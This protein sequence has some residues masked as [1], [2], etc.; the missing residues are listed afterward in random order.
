MDVVL[1]EE[2]L[3]PQ[4]W[5]GQFPR[6]TYLVFEK[7][8]WSIQKSRRNIG[9][10]HAMALRVAVSFLFSTVLVMFQ[11]RLKEWEH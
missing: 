2:T 7:E 9:L 3:H 6:N 4:R 1:A 10:A 8:N 5:T 11:V